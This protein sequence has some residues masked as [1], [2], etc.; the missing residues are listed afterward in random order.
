MALRLLDDSSEDTMSQLSSLIIGAIAVGLGSGCML[1]QIT[2][3]DS[4]SSSCAEDEVEDPNT[5][6]CWKRCRGDKRWT[7]DHC[8]SGLSSMAAEP[9]ASRCIAPSRLPSRDEMVRFL[10][11]CQLLDGS[12]Q[13]HSCT[14]SS[15]CGAVYGSS[16]DVNTV[17]IWTSTPCTMPPPLM[18][19][20]Y[21]LADL[22]DGTVGCFWKDNAVGSPLCV[23]N[24]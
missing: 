21:Y 16:L 2:G 14:A 23:R 7:G 3:D 12:Y 13:C 5:G 15:G 4:A 22:D 10:D 1:D 9:A 11:N 6:L 17:N 24:P 18:G 20:G 8:T 19:A